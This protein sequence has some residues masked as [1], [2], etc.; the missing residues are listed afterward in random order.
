MARKKSR[1]LSQIKA[2]DRMAGKSDGIRTRGG[3]MLKTISLVLGP[4]PTMTAA[5]EG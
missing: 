4:G 3:S 1:D 5:V 2:R